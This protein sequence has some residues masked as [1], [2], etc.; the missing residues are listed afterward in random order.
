MTSHRHLIKKQLLLWQVS[1]GGVLVDEAPGVRNRS[2]Y[3]LSP[4]D[5]ASRSE[6]RVALGV[7]AVFAIVVVV[8]VVV[9]WWKGGG[10]QCQNRRTRLDVGLPLHGLAVFAVLLG[11]LGGVFVA[12]FRA[13]PVLHGVG[14]VGLSP[15]VRVGLLALALQQSVVDEVADEEP[16]GGDDDHHAA[17]EVHLL[18]AFG[19]VHQ[20]AWKK[21]KK[22]G[23]VKK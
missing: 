22:K 2:L 1:I 5:P 17:A 14:V 16:Y 19:D 3:Y 20:F 9:Y 8:V 4:S 18:V 7:V 21:V 12:P 13:L 23:W 10:S 11:H 6:R 15:F